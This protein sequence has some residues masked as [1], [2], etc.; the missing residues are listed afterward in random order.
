MKGRRRKVS[1]AAASQKG[2]SAAA[3]LSR[4]SELGRCDAEFFLISSL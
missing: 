4:G 3:T 1:Y 2:E